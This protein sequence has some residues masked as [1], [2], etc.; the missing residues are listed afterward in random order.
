[1]YGSSVLWYCRGYDGF[2]IV[3]CFSFTVGLLSFTS[4]RSSNFWRSSPLQFG[5]CFWNWI[6]MA[7]WHWLGFDV[8]PWSRKVGVHVCSWWLQVLDRHSPPE[9]SEW[10]VRCASGFW[11]TDGLSSSSASLH[12]NMVIAF[13]IGLEY[14]LLLVF[15]SPFSVAIRSVLSLYWFDGIAGV[16]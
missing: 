6:W 11:M 8:L 5:N 7:S 13:E 9:P 2:F 10:I 16:L 4:T 3:F 14:Q 15:T 1:M 12:Y